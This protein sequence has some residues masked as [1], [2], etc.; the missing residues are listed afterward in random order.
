[1]MKKEGRFCGE[2]YVVLATP[3]F[4]DIALTKNKSYMGRRYIEIFRAKKLVDA[5]CTISA[6]SKRC[7]RITIVLCSR[8]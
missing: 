6:L 5:V 1:M 8:R 7:F 2:A 4:V 3:L